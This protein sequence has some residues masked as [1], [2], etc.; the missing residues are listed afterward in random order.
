M[1]EQRASERRQ[2]RAQLKRGLDPAD[3]HDEVPSR[4]GGY[5][6]MAAAPWSV[7]AA[8]MTAG[9][10]AA[11]EIGASVAR[12]M[13]ETTRGLHAAMMLPVAPGAGLAEMQDAF[14]TLVM[15][16]VQ[17]NIRL[18]QEMLRIYGPQENAP[19]VQRSMRHWMDTVVE[20][21]AAVLRMLRPSSEAPPGSAEPRRGTHA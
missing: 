7:E 11:E 10:A 14:A 6:R 18:T 3:R 1:V 16:V 5:D 17:N 12:L 13:Q 9:S 15:G 20:S 19:L 2:E 4:K 21:Q 8:T